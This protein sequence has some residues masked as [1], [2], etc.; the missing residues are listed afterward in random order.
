MCLDKFF[1]TVHPL[2]HSIRPG[3]I[4]D[5]EA[6]TRNNIDC[7]IYSRV[8]VHFLSGGVFFMDIRE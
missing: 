2:T 4:L 7:V 5:I 8:D 6:K 3:T 1:L